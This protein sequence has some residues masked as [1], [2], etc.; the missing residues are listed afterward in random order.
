VTEDVLDGPVLDEPVADRPRGPRTSFRRGRDYVAVLLIVVVLVVAGVLVAMTSDIGA[1]TSQTGPDNVEVPSAPEA[2]PPSF[3][4][5]WRAPSPATPE[6][7]VAGPAVVTGEGNEVIGHDPL[8]GDVRWRYKRDI[9]L[10]TVSAAWTDAIA[11]Y[12]PN[13]NSLPSGDSY[14][15]GNCSEV[16]T[17]KGTSGERDRQ[18]NGDAELGTRLLSDGLHVTATGKSLINTWRSDMVLTMQYGTVPDLVNPGKQPRTGCTYGSITVSPG[19]IGVLERCPASD[20]SDRVTVYKP[21][22]KDSDTPTVDFSAQTGG[23][24]AR[25][26]AV[27]DNFAAVVLPNPARLLVFD[28]TGNKTAE[29]PLTV[30]D[31][32]LTSDPPAG[33]VPSTRSAGAIYWFTG[34]RTIALSAADLSPMWTLESTMGPGTTFVG[35]LLVPMRD[36]LAVVD[37]ATG[38]RVATAPVN[39]HGYTGPVAMSTIGPVVLEQRGPTLVALR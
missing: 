1:T 20:G 7:A 38:A 34:S 15:G 16:T 22:A 25:V 19:R 9:P 18:R 14:K 24:G 12:R 17:L 37:Q 39:R 33:V 2:L 27:N 32:D 21:T 10:C 4:E 3:G 8:T 13:G 28:N 31:A 26:V 29:Y 5:V 36:A 6:P 30:P 11:V 35:Y 23:F